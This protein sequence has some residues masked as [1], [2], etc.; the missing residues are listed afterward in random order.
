MFLESIKKRDWEWAV[1]YLDEGR[2][3]PPD[4]R[5]DGD[6]LFQAQDV[7]TALL[8]LFS[9]NAA[10]R[11][12]VFGGREGRPIRLRI[13]DRLFSLLFS[14]TPGQRLLQRETGQRGDPPSAWVQRCQFRVQGDRV[15]LLDEYGSKVLFEDVWSPDDRRRFSAFTELP[16]LQRSFLVRDGQRSLH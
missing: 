14:Q 9:E 16:E 11:K 7:N 2:E 6:S 13:G 12:F 5:V 10:P 1:F 4:Y 3:V 8:Q 15:Q